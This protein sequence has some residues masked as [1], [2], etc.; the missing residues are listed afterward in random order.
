MELSAEQSLHSILIMLNGLLNLLFFWSGPHSNPG[1]FYHWLKLRTGLHPLFGRDKR[2]TIVCHTSERGISHPF[3]RT[4]G[5]SDEG[6]ALGETQIWAENWV[7]L[8]SAR[9]S[10]SGS[11][12]NGTTTPSLLED[13]SEKSINQVGRLCEQ[14]QY[15]KF[16]VMWISQP[17]MLP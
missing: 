1:D 6:G 12:G 5:I 11:L 15:T 9:P 14:K 4:E 16:C 17:I 13:S 3:G 8:L 7:N 2:T 10:V